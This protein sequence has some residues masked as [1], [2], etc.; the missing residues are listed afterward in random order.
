MMRREHGIATLLGIYCAILA[1]LG[2]SGAYAFIRI[3]SLPAVTEVRPKPATVLNERLETARAIKAALAKP[4]KKAEPLPPITAK[5]AHP[6][7]SIT[8]ARRRREVQIKPS[9]TAE[10]RG[11]M[12]QSLYSHPEQST[13][14]KLYDRTGLNGW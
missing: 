1:L 4:Q 2:L 12:A 14:V 13:T 6:V 8:D 5:L 9:L 7:S 3:A 11:A 10:A